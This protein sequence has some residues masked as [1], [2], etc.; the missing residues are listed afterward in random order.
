MNLQNFISSITLS[1]A[2]VFILPDAKNDIVGTWSTNGDNPGRIEI[3]PDGKYYSGKI[4]WVQNSMRDGK[5]ITDEK[6]PDP[7][8][9]EQAI[10]GLQVLEGFSYNSA[11]NLWEDGT[12]YDPESGNVYS[13]IIRR[14]GDDLRVRGYI[15]ISLLGRTE[16]WNKFE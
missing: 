10:I 4:V 16:I 7:A 3:Y 5:L 13:C 9:R 14:E 12:I 8:K 1:L 11:K 15:G 6:N 2:A